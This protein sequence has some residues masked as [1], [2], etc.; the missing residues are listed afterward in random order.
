MSYKADITIIGA[1]VVGLAIAAEVAGK[2]REVYVLEKNESFGQEQSSRNSEVIHA[3]IYYR[4]EYLKAK[5]CLEANN[6]LYEL[7]EKNGIPCIKCG[8]I[9]AATSDRENKGLEKL[10]NRGRDNGIPLKM[11]SRREM[12]Q[13]EPELRGTAAFLS[14]TTGIIDSY[15]LMRY[16]LAK[17]QTDDAHIAYKTKVVSIEKVSDGYKVSVE[18]PSGNFSFNTT[19]LINSAGLYSDRVSEMAGID[20][21]EADYRLHWCKGEYYSVSGGKNKRI[22]RL[23]YPVPLHISVG[24]HVCLDVSWRL[25]L[26]PTFYYVDEINYKL[27]DSKREILLGSSIMKALPVIEPAD[28]EPESAGIL[29]MLQGEGEGS[30][31]FVIRHEQ[32]RGLPGFINLIGIES[33]GLTASPAIAKYVSRIVKE[34]L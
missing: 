24:A 5:L 25:R 13:L 29:A 28:L 22:N 21:D 10:Y 19:V 20:I 31:D 15:A 14:P 12:R 23:I 33:P 11:L 30:R 4:K 8:K 34:I 9:I 6:L 1:G 16:F 17:A 7:C 32:D 26:G 3:G 2:G 27:D 18:G